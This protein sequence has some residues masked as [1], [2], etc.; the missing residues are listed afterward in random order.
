VLRRLFKEEATRAKVSSVLASCDTRGCT[1]KVEVKISISAG[2]PRPAG[3]GK[4]N[5]FLFS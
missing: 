2:Q 3:G 1:K 5:G 4:R